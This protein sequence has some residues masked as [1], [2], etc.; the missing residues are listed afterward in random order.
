M[1]IV[2]LNN[3]QFKNPL[4]HPDDKKLQ[5]QLLLHLF[6]HVHKTAKSDY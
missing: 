2:I 1:E 4:Q 6:R 5:G 3:D